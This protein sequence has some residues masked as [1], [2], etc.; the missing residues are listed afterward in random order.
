M[1]GGGYWGRSYWP[2]EYWGSSSGIYT[3]SGCASPGGFGIISPAYIR[4]S[5]GG[6]GVLPSL[7]VVSFG[8]IALL[9]M[10][11]LASSGGFADVQLSREVAILGGFAIIEKDVC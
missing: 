4:V 10:I 11:E 1:W 3:A 6:I 8:G 7:P 9:P 5:L 2:A